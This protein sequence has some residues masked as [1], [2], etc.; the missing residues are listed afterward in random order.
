MKEKREAPMSPSLM[1][2][3]GFALLILLVTLLLM[4]PI[5]SQSR[6]VTPP[7]T[8]LFTA[9]SAVCVT[10]Q[11]L[12][13][14]GMH[15]SLF[16]QVVLIAAIQIGGLGVMTL[17]ALVSMAMGR[18]IGLRQRTILQE[19]VASFSV[20]GIVRLIRLALIGTATIEGLGAAAL[21]FRFV[22]MLGWAKGLWYSV[23][24]AISAFCNAGFDLMGPVSGSFSS[25]EC[26]VGDPLINLTVM[27]LILVAGLGFPVWQ[28]LA[29][30][31]LCWKKLRLH[32]RAVLALTA[33]LVLVPAALFFITERNATM[34]GM[35]TGT[36]VW[37][38]LFSAVTPRTAG[39]DTVPTGEL[40][41]AG[42]MLTLL[43]M[44]TGGNSGQNALSDVSKAVA[45]FLMLVG[46]SSG[47]TAGGAKTT[48]LLLVVLTAVSIL[49][50]EE[51]VHIF[52]RRIENDLLRRACSIVVVYLTLGAMATLAICAMQPEFTL[53]QVLIEVFSAIDTVGLTAGIT[54]QL[55]TASRVLL[56]LLMYAGRLGSMTFMILLTRR[57]PPAP[58]QYPTDKILVG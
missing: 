31:R 27:T 13:D 19:S 37:A 41:P 7:L 21:A 16:G 47:S 4:L 24:H 39:F 49:R 28:D 58:V 42:G 34:A 56:I 40:S 18:R 33:F 8:A 23:F 15:W 2:A 22:P 57:K 54:R 55:N 17:L 9:T 46:G 43:L 50:G 36:R 11:V 30:N 38:S 32:T 26:F 20:G 25:L 52:G 5:S 51:D 6:T 45:D 48:T 10:G 3:I 14:T 35:T 44:L 53:Q 1:I 29:Q 12:V